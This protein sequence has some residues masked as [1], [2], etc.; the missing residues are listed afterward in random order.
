[1]DI[2]KYSSIIFSLSHSVCIL[3]FF[4]DLT[5]STPQSLTL[6]FSSSSRLICASSECLKSRF[7]Q[8]RRKNLPL[9]LQIFAFQNT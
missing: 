9:E 8:G 6:L 3:N 1:M 5:F 7:C 2:P 4:I